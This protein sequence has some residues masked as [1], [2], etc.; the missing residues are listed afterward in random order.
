MGFLLTLLL[1]FLLVF[2]LM[3]RIL[4]AFF[5]HRARQRTAAG[6]ERTQ[7]PAPEAA[8]ASKRKR[9][10]KDTGEYVDFEEIKE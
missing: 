2:Y 6:G 9:I 8:T 3:P 5:S 7:E 10:D 1:F 4:L